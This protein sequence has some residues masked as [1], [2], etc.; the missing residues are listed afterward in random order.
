MGMEKKSAKYFQYKYEKHTN[1]KGRNERRC[2][3]CEGEISKEKMMES[4]NKTYLIIAKTLLV[5]LFF[6]M[7]LRAFEHQSSNLADF[8]LISLADYLMRCY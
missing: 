1:I 5:F 3:S 4:F 8:F 2:E 7:W 6:L